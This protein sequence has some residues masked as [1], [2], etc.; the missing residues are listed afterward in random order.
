VDM[1]VELEQ[2]AFKMSVP[3]ARPSLGE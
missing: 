1:A 3:P 2:L